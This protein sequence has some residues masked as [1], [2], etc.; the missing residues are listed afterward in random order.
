MDEKLKKLFDYQR[1]EN[2]SRL[3][4]IIAETENRCGRE[5][6]DEELYFVNAAGEISFEAKKDLP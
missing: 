2:N 3:A 6:S 5:L 4:K 1:F